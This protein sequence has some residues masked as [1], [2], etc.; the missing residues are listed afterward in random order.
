MSHDALRDILIQ[1]RQEST[2]M[3]HWYLGVEHLFIALLE[4]Q[5]GLTV[6]LLQDQGLT[7][8]YVIEAI[9]KKTGK[10]GRTRLWAGLPNTPRADIVLGIAQDLAL[11]EG[12]ESIGERDLLLAILE[13]G[14]SLPLRVMRQ[15]GVDVVRLAEAAAT[16]QVEAV[17]QRYTLNI[18]FGPQYDP[19]H[20]LEN[21]HLYILRRMFQGYS[22][23]RVERQLHGGYSRAVVLLVTPVQADDTEDASLVVK[24]DRTDLILDE[25]RRYDQ[26]VRTI[27]PPLTARIE[28]KPTAPD[29]SELAGVRYTFV[30]DRNGVPRDLRSLASEWNGEVLGAW[31]KDALFASFGKTWWSQRRAYRFPAWM[32]YDWYLPPILTLDWSVEE[33]NDMTVIREPIKRARL[34][35]L[36]YGDTVAVDNFAVHKLYPERDEIALSVGRGT[37][38]ARRA[39]QINVRGVDQSGDTYYRGEEV[40]RI[41]GTVYKTR[42]EA[43]RMAASATQP[44]FDLRSEF[45][46]GNAYADRLPNPLHFY[47]TLLDAHLNGSVSKIHGDLHMSN[48]LVGAGDTPFL[49]DFAYT[50]DGHTL[51]DWAALEVSLW[52]DV[53]MPRMGKEWRD[54]Y[55]VLDAASALNGG[56]TFEPRVGEEALAEGLIA[57]TSLREIVGLC[58]Q[59]PNVWFEYYVALAFS[60]LRAL[61]WDNRPL[62]SR[63]LMFLLAA[64]AI[65]E[66]RQRKQSHRGETPTDGGMTDTGGS[67]TIG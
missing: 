14:D 43:L 21:D 51:A 26:H 46:A 60:A 49:I 18:T 1:A 11:E 45:L 57:L 53:V 37:E 30:A 65:Y 10:G 55:R 17:S 56:P 62:A 27:L 22:R 64:L 6:T 2:R 63:R 12:R 66:T 9:R 29:T 38:A 40:E 25:A 19:A 4:T 58:L 3:R 33:T 48:I 32:E 16:R 54:A 8:D 20:I 5:G 23:V 7:P 52:T 39:Y 42:H 35:A 13:E 31:L 44:N 61:T 50:R 67:M 47:D 41:V 59:V 15:F 28:D 24:I 34:T 36:E